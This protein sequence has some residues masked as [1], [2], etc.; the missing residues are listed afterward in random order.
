MRQKTKRKR[1]AFGKRAS[2]AETR[3]KSSFRQDSSETVGPEEVALEK[4]LV[5]SLRERGIELV[6]ADN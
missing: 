6:P 1:I 5:K 3:E 4:G 2:K